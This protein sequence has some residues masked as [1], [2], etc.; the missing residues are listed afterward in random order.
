MVPAQILEYISCAFVPKEK[1]RAQP[2]QTQQESTAPVPAPLQG[3]QRVL[4]SSRAAELGSKLG[5]QEITAS[6]VLQCVS[7]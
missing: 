7:N 3:Q 5:H 2:V 6:P 4:P 1:S